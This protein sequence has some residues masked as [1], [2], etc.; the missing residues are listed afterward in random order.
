MALSEIN[1]QMSKLEVFLKGDSK[2]FFGKRK[3]L[4]IKDKR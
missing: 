2:Y 1:H 4:F 3:K